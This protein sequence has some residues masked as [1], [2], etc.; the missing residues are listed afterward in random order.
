MSGML[1]SISR[2]LQTVDLDEVFCYHTVKEVRMLDR[3]LGYLC[4]TI[5]I[6][7]ASYVIGYVFIAQ[8]GYSQQELAVGH[9]V[10]EIS[11]T[12]YSISRGAARPWDEVDMVKPALENG[13]LFI[14]THALYTPHQRMGNCTSPSKKCAVNSDCAKNPPLSDA[15]CDAGM[16]LEMQWCPAQSETASDRTYVH[17]IEGA[18]GTRI[19]LKASIMFPSL[20]A[21]R[22]FS[23]IDTEKPTRYDPDEA[24]VDG[25][26]VDHGDG[27]TPPDE[28]TLAELLGLAGTSYEVV[29]RTGCVLSVVAHW[30]CYVDDARGCRPE[31][32]VDRLDTSERRKGFRYEYADYYR[33]APAAPDERNYYT[34]RGVRL[35]LSSR[36]VGKRVSLSAIMLQISSLIALLW[37]ANYAADFLMLHV[38]PEKRHYRTYKQARGAPPSSSPPR[39]RA[40]H[41][42]AHA[43]HPSQERTPDFSDL[44]NKI[45][46]VEGEK[47]KL[48]ERKNRFAARMDSS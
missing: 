3:R 38:L 48:R 4:W 13:A 7:I 43:P 25:G 26:K 23:T 1:N 45:A 33:S 15:H 41:A 42:A 32:S 16:C 39:A 34:Y 30:N 9:V 44:R 20:D 28:F 6:L 17:P 21:H 31:V 5:R 27:N 18:E 8:E 24:H 37:L 29:R 12:A 10:P 11:G 47:R 35:V 40:R 36:G 46:E 14:A 19:W 22:I 2:R